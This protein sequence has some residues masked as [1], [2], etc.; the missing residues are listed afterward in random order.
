[1]IAHVFPGQGSQYPGMAKEFTEAFPTALAMMQEADDLL[2]INLKRAML[3]GPEDVLR[4]TDFTQPAIFLH[5]MIALKHDE[6][7]IIPNAA[8]GHSL[9]EYTALCAAGALE[10]K[11][12]L[13]LVHLR[14][15]LMAEA[16]K[17]STGTM[18]AIVGM[19]A[20]KLAALCEEV[21]AQSSSVVRPANF[22]SPGQIVIS[23]STFGV[24]EVM[25]RAKETGVRIAKELPV[26]GA[27]HSP[28]MQYAADGL[29]E[30]LQSTEITEPS[31]P[32]FSN[33]TAE[34]VES[35]DDIRRLLVEQLTAPVRWE[36]SV[37]NMY[38]FGIREFVEYGPGKVLQ[39]LISRTLTN[40]KV[41]GIEKPKVIAA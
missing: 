38:D 22:N 9:G 11:D 31:I 4:Q 7:A 41:T 5:S 14:G 15:T 20:T 34:P 19:D 12:A 27:F 33:V 36:E 39:G 37:K 28:L 1:M 32:V 29:K 25:R 13:Q 3:E 8:A 18:A 30:A 16:G 17:R 35:A 40:V 23:G 26:S 24:H 10:F 2:H 6:D 21:E